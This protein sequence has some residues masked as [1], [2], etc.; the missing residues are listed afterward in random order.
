[1]TTSDR[2]NF[3]PPKAQNLISLK[4]A[5]ALVDVDPK[6]IMNWIKDGDL[7]G[8]RVKDRFWRVDRE[9]VLALAKPVV[10][11]PAGGAA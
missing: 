5:G 3:D 7:Q 6:T 2:F 4:T 1:M 11:P 10:L 9:E 8:F